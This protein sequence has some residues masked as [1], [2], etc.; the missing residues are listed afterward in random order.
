MAPVSAGTP[1]VWVTLLTKPLM[2]LKSTVE[3]VTLSNNVAPVAPGNVATDWFT[4]LTIPCRL[5]CTDTVFKLVTNDAP[6]CPAS[7]TV[8]CV[9]LLA[10]PKFAL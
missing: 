5:C 6:F 9:T 7:S 10:I 3:L 1:T 8:D 4:V 2:R